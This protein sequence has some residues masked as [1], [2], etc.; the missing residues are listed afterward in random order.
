MKHIKS[1][2]LL[3][4]PLLAGMISEF[5]MYLSD[6]AMVGRL[7]VHYLA[8][9][10]IATMFAEIL[11]IIIWPLAPATQT[12]ASQRY[13][14]AI[15]IEKKDGPE[16]RN[17]LRS[18]GDVFNNSLLFA[19]G[20]GALAVLL[21]GLCKPF[22]LL[23]LD[24]VS[25]I[26]L[27]HS[28]VN[29]VK[30]A[31]PVAAVFYG[32]Y[33]FLAAINRTIP[34]MIVTIGLNILNIGFNYLLIFG[35]FGCPALGIEGAAIGTVLAQVFGAIFLVL[36]VLI[37]KNIRPYNCFRF[38]KF[39][40]KVIKSLLNAGTPI[41]GE[42]V[43]VFVIYLYYETLIANLGTVY[44]AAT[45]IVFTVF[46]LKRTIV[47]GFAEGGSILVGNNLGRQNRAE[48][49][50]YAFA[51]EWIGIVIGTVLFTLILLFPEN[52]VRVFNNEAPT[53]AVGKDALRFF[54]VFMLID[55]IGYP[56]EVIF[57]HNGWGKFVF[58]AGAGTNFIF[59]LGLS[60][61]LLKVL[62]MGIYAAWSAFAIQIVFY[63][64]ILTVG[65][66]SK[67]WLYVDVPA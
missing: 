30:W 65:F 50:K 51:A 49:V 67:R 12:I 47:G 62:N 64:A 40:P 44:L 4:A 53:I 32:L 2:M 63:M 13:G 55:V 56:F 28:Y 14:R 33:G 37:S 25:L 43:I 34:I 11:W 48:A 60:I 46:I 18:T 9:M 1:V 29:I 7:G 52:I 26:P 54:A 57:T 42:L 38:K 66:F 6:S 39:D 61:I 35:K 17:K 5:F 36:Y 20:A 21:A 15:A 59:L 16:Y 31:M 23:V 10:G 24:D 41:T 27:I 45:H 19:L 22:L 58:F 3:G 8:A